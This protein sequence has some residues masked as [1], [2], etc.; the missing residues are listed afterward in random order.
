MRFFKSILVLSALA[1]AALTGRAE[2]QAAA[3]SPYFVTTGDS[4]VA[5]AGGWGD[6]FVP[7]LRSPAGGGATL[8]R[9]VPRRSRS[10]RRASGT[11]RYRLGD[12]KGSSEVIVTVQFGH[13]DQKDTS[14]ITPAQFKANLKTMVGEVKAAGGTPAL[15]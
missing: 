7:L 2:E 8:P 3:L 12:R 13:N 4:T 15:L 5:T 11:R 10:G 14:G 1:Q 6:G 9:A